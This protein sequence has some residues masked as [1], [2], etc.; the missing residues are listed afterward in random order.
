MK[1]IALVA[2][3]CMLSSGAF[4]Q[5]EIGL[6]VA[7]ALAGNRF[8]AE[9]RHNMEKTSMHARFGVGLLVDYFFTQNYA[10]STGINYTS[11][12]SGIRY[13]PTQNA[14]QVTDRFSLQYVEI[15]V[16]MKM[17][18]NEVAPDVKVYFHLG[19]S[20]NTNIS[21]KVNDEKLINGEKATKRFN[22]FEVSGVLGT[23]V[24]YQLG[25]T[26]RVFGGLAYHRG[27]TN[28]DN[29]YKDALGDKNISIRSDSFVLDLGLKF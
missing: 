20:I 6:R 13:S 29:Y 24:E 2:F 21:A 9:S 8:I 5:F 7:P 28:I 27:L 25:Q 12:G 19:P 11:K 18:T 23:G 10:L 1:K 22:L 4:A 26:T 15:P 3:L 14:G 17:Y 16:M